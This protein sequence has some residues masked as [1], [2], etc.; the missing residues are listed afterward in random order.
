MESNATATR[1]NMLKAIIDAV[2][3]GMP[4]PASIILFPETE[5]LT[6]TMPD[7]ALADVEAWA[8]FLNATAVLDERVHRSH[9]GSLG[10]FWRSYSAGGEW[11]KWHLRVWC[12]APLNADESAERERIEAAT[13]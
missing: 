2:E 7:G 5:Y 3:F 8:G 6:L 13:C 9:V 4:A 11:G 1:I 10:R 12:V